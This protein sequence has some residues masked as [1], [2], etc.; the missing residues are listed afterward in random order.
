M[1]AGY[2]WHFPSGTSLPPSPVDLTSCLITLFTEKK[3]LFLTLAVSTINVFFFQ[4]RTSNLNPLL[5]NAIRKGCIQDLSWNKSLGSQD[6]LFL[7]SWSRQ[8]E[9]SIPVE[10]WVW[11]CMGPEPVGVIVHGWESLQWLSVA[12]AHEH[13]MDFFSL[14]LYVLRLSA[15]YSLLAHIAGSDTKVS[16]S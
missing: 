15:P 4:F 1:S 13:Q 11:V 7:M 2:L 16:G 14:S 10:C 9:W 8:A 5:F 12:I 3:N 6:Q